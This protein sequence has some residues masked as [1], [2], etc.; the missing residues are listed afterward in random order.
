MTSRLR[1]VSE[2]TRS[3]ISNNLFWLL[4]V[5]TTGSILFLFFFYQSFS[6]SLQEERKAQTKQLSEVGLAIINSFHQLE[7]SCALTTIKAQELA[8]NALQSATYG[9]NGY[10]WLNDGK[11]VLLMQPYAPEQI[12]I[13]H[14]E[15]TD[16]DN[17]KI[18]RDFIDQ[19]HKGGGWVEYYWPKPKA[20]QQ[21][22]KLSYVAYF[23]PWDW[24]LGTGLYLDDM[25]KNIFTTITQA[26]GIF[27]S[28]FVLFIILA[29]LLAQYF[30]KQLEGLA[31]RDHLTGLFTK[32]FLTESI[33]VL[34]KKDKRN[35]D[36]VLAAFFIDLDHFK[37]INDSYGH[38]CG[39]RV[40]TRIA[41]TIQENTRP[42]DLCI[43]Y[44]GEEFVV[45]GFFKKEKSLVKF[46]QR[47]RTTAA[48]EHF[49]HNN[50]VFSITLSIGIATHGV[51]ET[52]EQTI[53]RADA[54]L[55]Q[56]KEKGRNCIEIES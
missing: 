17:N 33:P 13:N 16:A 51:N 22:L 38:A 45:V 39:D 28:C 10:F 21:S 53:Q 31:I 42:E 46:A 29:V 52:F 15:W 43:R 37:N 9:E 50:Q 36:H 12:G 32:R 5:C 3:A 8:S 19:A 27:L 55:Y 54:Q 25:E 1:L 14:I 26:S 23:A 49:A 18:F 20:E 47:I 34:L 35:R 7:V 6:T 56:A 24:V 41:N 11:G 48:K 40:L 2:P 30:I 44:G 4:F